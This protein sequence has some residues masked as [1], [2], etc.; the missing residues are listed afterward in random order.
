[1]NSQLM[2]PLGESGA[3]PVKKSAKKPSGLVPNFRKPAVGLPSPVPNC[4]A[5]CWG[6]A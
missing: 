5:F 6:V 4:Q 1:M 2:K 3:R